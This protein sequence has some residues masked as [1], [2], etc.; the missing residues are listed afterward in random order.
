MIRVVIDTDVF[1]S[2]FF[3]GNPKRIIDLWKNEEIIL[4]LS[5]DVLDE[6]IDVLQRVG[7][8]D[9]DEIE[10]LLSL[11]ARGFNILFT[12]KT[13]RIKAVKEDPEDNK[14]IECA[15]ALKA[16][17]VV[18]GDKALRTVGDYMGIKILTPQELL[19]TFKTD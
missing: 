8:K 14:F 11:F 19:K 18:T 7:L 16:E 2:S 3:G 6:Y 5:K 15:V 13:P 17:F 12:A 4:C 9:E 1:V 10:E